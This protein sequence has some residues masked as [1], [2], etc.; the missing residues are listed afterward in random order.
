VGVNPPHIV[1]VRREDI[2]KTSIGKIQ[3]A[4]LARRFE[5]GDFDTILNRLQAAAA[6]RRSTNDA[7]TDQRQQ[8]IVRVWQEVLGLERIG[9]HDSFFDLGGQSLHLAQVRSKLLDEYQ[10]DVSL[11]TLLAYPTVSALAG[12]LG[13]QGDSGPTFDEHLDRSRAR[14][15]SAGRRRARRLS[16]R[17]RAAPR[18]NGV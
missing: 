16:A 15:A 14:K 5:N 11:I 12:H 13:S 1:P 7:P 4:P 6:A 2:P 10:I 3:R 9:S 17:T 8:T 18:R